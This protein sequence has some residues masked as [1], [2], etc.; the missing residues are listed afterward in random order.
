LAAEAQLRV[1]RTY[2]D[3]HRYAEAKEEYG[4]ALDM[5]ITPEV[6]YEAQLNSALSQR[7]LAEEILSNPVFEPTRRAERL[8]ASVNPAT[9]PVRPTLPPRPLPEAPP[10]EGSPPDSQYVEPPVDVRAEMEEAA[11]PDSASLADSLAAQLA[12]DMAMAAADT[13][14]VAP[15]TDEQKKQLEAAER[16]VKKV[17]EQLMGLRKA[18]Q[19]LSKDVDLD[20]ELAVTHALMVNL[21]RR[22]PTSIRSRA[23]P[24]GPRPRRAPATKLA[25]CTGV[26]VNSTK[27]APPT[28]M[29]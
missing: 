27:R 24:R 1:A 28:M 25:K 16:E 7:A 11:V 4:R 26:W 3:E 21:T 8:A 23:P 9:R 29:R 13:Q 20:I 10:P 22:S 2:Y 6:R 5:K 15:L 14:T 19:K 18:A 12:A 17:E